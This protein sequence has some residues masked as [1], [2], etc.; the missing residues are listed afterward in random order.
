M[1]DQLS[2]QTAIVTGASSGNGR[3]IA[4]TFAEEGAAVVC[5]D[6][7]EDPR[8][9]GYEDK[10]ELTTHDLIQ[11][12]G[13]D[14]V[15]VECDVTD[16]EQIRSAIDTAVD[17]F[18]QLDIMVNNAGIF[19]RLVD[20]T[21]TT[22][23]E[24]HKTIE[25]NLTGVWN[26]TK[27]AVEQFVEQGNGGKVVNIASIGGLVGLQAEPA[28]SASKGGVVNFTRATALDCAP[29]EINV[30]AV[31]PGWISTAM[32]REYFDD[33]EFWEQLS[34]STP[35]PRL[36]VPQDVADACLILAGPYAEWITGHALTVDGGYTTR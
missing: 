29:H 28:Y 18:G 22:Q 35:W 1:T 32:T 13:G 14:A 33:D 6:I 31:C 3:A 36:G 23:E 5:A 12:N 19:T 15:F 26:G 2:G 9:G 8:E 30:N 11:E 7:I 24:W 25:V 16:R 34:E 17:E 10:S 20:I 27:E 21:E 4:K